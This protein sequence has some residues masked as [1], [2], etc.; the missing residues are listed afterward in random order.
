MKERQKLMIVSLEGI[1]HPNVVILE[2]SSYLG[3]NLRVRS[4]RTIHSLLQSLLANR[5]LQ[6]DKNNYEIWVSDCYK[7]KQKG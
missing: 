6:K 5:P 1:V 2:T 4:E 3:S 7:I